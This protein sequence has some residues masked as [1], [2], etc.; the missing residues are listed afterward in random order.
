ML[1]NRLAKLDSGERD[2]HDPDDC[3]ILCHAVRDEAA[4]CGP[5]RSRRLIGSMC[6]IDPICHTKVSFMPDFDFAVYLRDR[7]CR[8]EG[9]DHN[10]PAFFVR[11]APTLEP[12]EVHE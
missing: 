12:R 11:D 7:Q 3:A 6:T 4:Q 8:H 5:R 10:R 9:R 2:W 1:I